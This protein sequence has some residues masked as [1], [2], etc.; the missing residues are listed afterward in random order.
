MIKITGIIVV[1]SKLRILFS[2]FLFFLSVFHTLF[3]FFPLYCQN[4]NRRTVMIKI[5]GIIVVKSKLRIL[6]SSFLFFLSVFHTLFVFFPFH[7][8]NINRRT[9]MIKITGIIVV[10]SKLRILFSSF[11]FF[12]SVFHTLFVFFP[13]PLPVLAW[14]HPLCFLKKITEIMSI[15]IP[16]LACDF[17]GTL[18]GTTEKFPRLAH[19]K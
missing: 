1:K 12:L 17:T 18:C 3:V 6:F 16:H 5:T 9:V 13:F 8:Q 15:L 2:S 4:I 10:K 14:R 7:C 19:T 11:L